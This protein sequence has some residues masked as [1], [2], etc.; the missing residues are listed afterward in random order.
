M[1]IEIIVLTLQN[2]NENKMS[3]IK[4][5]T[6]EVLPK[7]AQVTQV[8]NQKNTIS[9]LEN[10]LLQ[11]SG[12]GNMNI[13]ASDGETWLSINTMVEHIDGEV[14]CCLNAQRLNTALR[15][16]G[17]DMEV[18]L[19]FDEQS[20][21]AKFNYTS[22]KFELPFLDADDFPNPSTTGEETLTV[23]LLNNH[24]LDGLGLTEF[25]TDNDSLHPQFNG[26]HIDFEKQA[27]NS[28]GQMVFVSTDTR[29]L[30]KYTQ[31]LDVTLEALY[32]KGFTLPKKAASIILQLLANSVSGESCFMYFNEQSFSLEGNG[33][34]L[35]TRLIA[36]RFPNYN[37]VIPTNNNK[38]AV[39]K[40]DAIIGALK[41]V[42]AFANQKTLMATL[43][44]EN[45]KVKLN[46]KD[47]DYNTSAQ[48]TV[49]CTYTDEPITIGFPC[50]GLIDVI[51]N[52][53]CED[54]AIRLSEPQRAGLIQPNVQQDDSEYLSIQMPMQV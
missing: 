40:R 30:V 33:A 12:G 22:G 9:I 34:K 35:S 4:F 44:F 51:K 6:S 52:V 53:R 24:L 28:L 23:E 3:K 14:H 31:K 13:T 46:T 48:E 42:M 41:R 43:E 45:N 27:E 49:D 20:H 18:E 29:K 19:E 37:A 54:V 7:V 2:Q 17:N 26:I 16:L 5:K 50:N 36:G 10:V 39:V 25:A 38:I 8:V 47:I 15:S 21:I 32:D 11:H 1:Y